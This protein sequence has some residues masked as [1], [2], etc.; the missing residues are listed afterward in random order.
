MLSDKVLLDAGHYLYS[1]HYANTF[2]EHGGRY[3]PGSEI[4][5]CVNAAPPERLLPIM[6]HYEEKLAA[7]WGK[8]VEEVAEL[9]DMGDHQGQVDFV[10]LTLMQCMGHGV[11][12]HDDHKEN[13]DLYQERT[14]DQL[15]TAPFHTEMNRLS[16]LA[17]EYLATPS[18]EYAVYEKS[19]T[20]GGEESLVEGKF[21]T[22]EAAEQWLKDTG[23]GWKPEDRAKYSIYEMEEDE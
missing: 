21:H 3:S 1:L 14:G 19:E 12:M 18:P 23:M 17:H 8:P 22:A 10:Y 7:K 13:L 4:S 5:N 20:P 2:E 9:L 16:D 6:R 11:S 15:D